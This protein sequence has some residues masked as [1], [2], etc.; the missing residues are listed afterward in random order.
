MG[1]NNDQAEATGAD[2]ILDEHRDVRRRFVRLCNERTCSDPGEPTLAAAWQAL[3][4]LLE[5][6]ATTQEREVEKF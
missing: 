1:E 5:N 6:H 3:A 4:N 2:P